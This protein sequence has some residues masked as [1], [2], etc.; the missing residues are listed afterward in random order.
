MKLRTCG[1]SGL[2]LPVLGMGCWAYGGGEYWGEQS[3]RDVDAVVRCA[4]EHGCN[5]FDTAEAYNHGASESSLGLALA[6]AGIR[7]EEVLV[8]TKISPS[9]TAPEVLVEHCNASLKRLALPDGGWLYPNGQDWGLRRNIDWFEYDT[10]LAVMKS[11]CP[12]EFSSDTTSWE[13]STSSR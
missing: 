7:R 1:K 13:F 5:F 9:N 3:Q 2:A 8:C 12:V 4:V 11:T 10:A 6:R